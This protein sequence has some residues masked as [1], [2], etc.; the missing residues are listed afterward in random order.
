[1]TEPRRYPSAPVQ[2]PLRQVELE[3]T[4][5]EGCAGCAELAD[6]RDRA[7]AGHDWT[8]V[9]DC[10]VLLRRHPKGHGIDGHG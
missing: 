10:N 3:P 7:R 2:L 1:M 5:V 8:T 4:P 9:A 6:V